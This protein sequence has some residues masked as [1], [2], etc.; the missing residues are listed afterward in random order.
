MPDFEAVARLGGVG[1][2]ERILLFVRG[3]MPGGPP[4]SAEQAVWIAMHQYRALS[5]AV[6]HAW[7]EAMREL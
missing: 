7:R 6:F 5:K 2:Y 1:P 3:W 4:G